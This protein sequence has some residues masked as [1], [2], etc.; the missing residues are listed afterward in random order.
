MIQKQGEKNVLM[1]S[2]PVDEMKNGFQGRSSSCRSGS[3]ISLASVL[4]LEGVIWVAT[5]IFSASQHA[6]CLPP[7]R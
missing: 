7:T 5:S 3:G 6:F 1:S 4:S 2:M